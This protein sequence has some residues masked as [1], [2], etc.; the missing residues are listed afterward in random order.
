MTI[1]KWSAKLVA[2]SAIAAVFYTAMAFAVGFGDISLKSSL[3]EPLE[4][5]IALN[6]IEGIDEQMLL[7]QLAP[8]Q[9]FIQAGISREY[10]LT[11]LDFTLGK[12]AANDT[13]IKVTSE[14]PV[15]EPYLDFLVQL[16]WP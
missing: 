16:E 7:V 14:Q 4:A 3:N 6:N 9:A 2:G 8:A 15:V 1:R 11:Q 12:N 13:V 10:Y 5:E